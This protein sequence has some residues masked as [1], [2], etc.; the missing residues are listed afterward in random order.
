M[1]DAGDRAAVYEA[2]CKKSLRRGLGFRDSSPKLRHRS[3]LEVL[4]E[5][6]L[7]ESWDLVMRLKPSSP[8][9]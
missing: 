9:Q 6:L 8:M 7:G 5:V 1:S 2:C 4:I 3:S